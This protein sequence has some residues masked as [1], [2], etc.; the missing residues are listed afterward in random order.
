MG[1]LTTNTNTMKTAPKLEGFRI[2]FDNCGDEPHFHAGPESELTHDLN[3]ARP[4]TAEDDIELTEWQA[5]VSEKLATT[6]AP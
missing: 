3:D 1:V 5:F 6:S 2:W 4:W